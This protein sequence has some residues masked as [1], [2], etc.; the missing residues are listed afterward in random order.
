MPTKKK[1]K[2]ATKKKYAWKKLKNKEDES[3]F[4]DKREAKDD[5]TKAAVTFNES[6]CT[7]VSNI[8]L[9][10]SSSCLCKS[11]LQEDFS[12]TAKPHLNETVASCGTDL[13]QGM[14]PGRKSKLSTEYVGRKCKHIKEK[15]TVIDDKREAKDDVAVAFNEKDGTN[16]VNITDSLR[17]NGRLEKQKS[18]RHSQ[19]NKNRGLDEQLCNSGLKDDYSHTVK[20]HLNET[21]ASCGTYLQQGMPPGKKSKLSTQYKRRKRRKRKH[22]EVKKTVIDDKRE[23]ENGVTKTAAAVN[24]TEC[25][26]V[27]L[28][29]HK[30]P[31]SCY[32]RIRDSLGLSSRLK[33]QKDKRDAQLKIKRGL[34]GQVCESSFEDDFSQTVEAFIEETEILIQQCINRVP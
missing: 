29:I 5:V 10:Q 20:T 26:N 9:K 27:S 22:D 13:Q 19:F 17:P 21:V 25:T 3:V 32:G 12:H 2:L 8:T 16:N 1:S 4:D 15:K 24:E 31:S 28:I 33:Q 6:E 23:A 14:P 30:Q 11:G 18:K 7:N 34:D